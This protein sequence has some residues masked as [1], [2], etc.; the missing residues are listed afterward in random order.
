VNQASSIGFCS[1]ADYRRRSS[2]PFAG[3]E[4]EFANTTQFRIT[5]PVD[6]ATVSATVPALVA[7]E[8]QL[9]HAA[10]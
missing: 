7:K 9:A 2:A 1:G 8:R 3:I 6:A 4:I 5:A 10:S